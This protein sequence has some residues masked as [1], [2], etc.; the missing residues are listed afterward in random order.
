VRIEPSRPPRRWPR[1]VLWALVGLVGI[2]VV[3][4]ATTVLM[5]DRSVTR[6]D[7]AGLGEEPD[8]P[9]PVEL[10]N[11]QEPAIDVPEPAA[12]AVTVLLLGSDSREVLTAEERRQLGTG[13]VDGERTEVVSLVHIDPDDE[14]IRMVQIPRDT[15]VERCDGTRGRINAAY[16][17]GEREGIGGMSCVVQTVTAWSG[18]T[19]DHAVKVDF[20]GFVDIVDAVGGVEM[21]IDEPLQDRRANLDLQPGCVHLDG[22]EA[23]AFVRARHLDDDF[24]RIARQHRFLQELRAQV[25][26]LGILQDLRRLVRLADATARSVEL[27]D[28]LTLGRIQQLV[29]G[30]RE[31][32]SGE[33]ETRTVPGTPSTDTGFF[34]LRPDEQRAAELFSWLPSGHD[35]SEPD[36]QDSDA[37]DRDDPDRGADDTPRGTPRPDS[38]HSDPTRAD[39]D[40]PAGATPQRCGLTGTA[41]QAMS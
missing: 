16:G 19:I 18:V 39:D 3:A 13:N 28:S 30:H 14:Q 41:N 29:M 21:Q 5:L 20:R 37:R 2:A 10:E 35:P 23:L 26:E 33:I 17:I 11:D 40:G 4:G 8:R 36:I 27:D 32:L 38:Q 12:D 9:E 22:A 15:L 1:R 25:G 6:V 24:G 31:V 34:F 7:V